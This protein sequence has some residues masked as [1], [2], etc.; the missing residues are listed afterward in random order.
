MSQFY[1]SAFLHTLKQ[2]G[3]TVLVVRGV[4]PDPGMLAADT[5]MF[6]DAGPRPQGRWYTPESAKEALKEADLEAKRAEAAAAALQFE[7]LPG[8]DAWGTGGAPQTSS[9]WA[10]TVISQ[11]RKLVLGGSATAW[12]APGTGRRLGSGDVAWTGSAMDRTASSSFA[13]S[14][15]ASDDADLERAIADSLQMHYDQEAQRRLAQHAAGTGPTAT[16]RE[17]SLQPHQLATTQSPLQSTSSPDTSTQ[18]PSTQQPSAQEQEVADMRAEEEV[19]GSREAHRPELRGSDREGSGEARAAG[20]RDGPSDTDAREVQGSGTAGGDTVVEL[21]DGAP[22][23]PGSAKQRAPGGHL[24]GGAS[25]PPPGQSHGERK[26]G[27]SVATVEL[28]IH[29]PSGERLRRTFRHEDCVEAVVQ[30]VRTH[31]DK[32]TR[33][34]LA[35]RGFGGKVGWTV[36]YTAD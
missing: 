27:A 1:L 34:I 13:A 12:A 4:F 36:V 19:G 25:P 33:F 32:N 31:L 5:S 11:A 26:E 2:E 24:P 6:P 3:W 16:P 10:P 18:T 20:T 15:A 8:A 7:S 21:G 17:P 22:L 35:E 29:L 9:G 23:P 14:A 28:A 30:F